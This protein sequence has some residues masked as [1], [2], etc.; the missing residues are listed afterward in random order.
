M[1][2][3]CQHLQ[4]FNKWHNQFWLIFRQNGVAPKM[5][6]PILEEVK[7]KVGKNKII[8][9]DVDRSPQAAGAYQIQGVPRSSCSK[10]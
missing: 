3:I 10:W 8:K 5:M 9:V 6:K 4:F 1:K 7:S 2:I